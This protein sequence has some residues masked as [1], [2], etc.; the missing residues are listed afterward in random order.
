MAAR[1][2]NFKSNELAGLKNKASDLSNDK[3]LIYV[4]PKSLIDDEENEYFYENYKED[5]ENLAASI[6]HDRFTEVI[7]AYKTEEGYKIRA[8]HRRKYAAIMAGLESVPVVVE[9]PPKSYYDRMIGLMDSNNNNREQTPMVLG[10]TAAKYFEIIQERRAN[11]E[12]YAEKVKG[13]ATKDLVAEKMAK[14]A[15]LVSKYARLVKLIPALQEKADMSDYSW[16]ALSSAAQ[17]DEIKQELLNDIINYEVEEHDTNYIKRDFL[18][19]VI[20]ELKSDLYETVE[21]YKC[22]TVRQ[23]KVDTATEN[24]NSAVEDVQNILDRIAEEGGSAET[25]AKEAEEGSSTG[26]GHSFTKEFA[27]ENGMEEEANVFSYKST[28]QS[29]K[30]KREENI[31]SAAYSLVSLLDVD[32]PF[33]KAELDLMRASLFTLQEKIKK[34]YE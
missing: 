7:C 16:S 31:R 29:R 34:L 3:R 12:E 20:S 18:E 5:I 6:K 11:D 21:E 25:E 15:S 27:E 13:I 9:Q 32:V 24:F 1:S 14:S 23:E 19:K 33:E 8:G 28:R 10:R 30:M 2:F 17:L 4:N 22:V 26:I